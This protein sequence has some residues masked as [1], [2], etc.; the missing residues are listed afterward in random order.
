MRFDEGRREEGP[1]GVD[2]VARRGGSGGRQGRDP[3]RLD[4]DGN[5]FNRSGEP[6]VG[7]EEIGHA[8]SVN[9]RWTHCGQPHRIRWK[10][11]TRRWGDWG[12]TVGTTADI[13]AQGPVRE[14]G[15]GSKG[16]AVGPG[17]VGY[18]PDR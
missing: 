8:G 16:T 14:G 17:G 13:D 12:E 11:A 2:D 4:R 10:P 7:N 3:A 6:G 15:Y 1:P 5:Q 9:A 18:I